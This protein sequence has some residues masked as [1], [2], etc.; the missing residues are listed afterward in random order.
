MRHDHVTS[1]RMSAI[2]RQNPP[3]KKYP[4]H[5]IIPSPP[6]S[7]S[8]N[9][10]SARIKETQKMSGWDEGAVYYSDQAHSW[11]DRGGDTANA[12]ADNHTILQK[13]KEFIRNFETEKN[14]FPYRESLVHNPKF[15]LV[16]MEDLDAFDADLPA[17][18]RSNP[19]DYLP[20]VVYMKLRLTLEQASL[21]ITH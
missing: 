19:A 6:N 5:P 17:K 13:F 20:L 15:L 4:I 9:L 10:P 21:L 2:S 14:V 7:Q 16:D 18:L 8:Q 12:T 11:D 1:Y 3:A